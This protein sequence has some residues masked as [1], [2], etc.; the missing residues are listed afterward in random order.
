MRLSR[1]IFPIFV[2]V[3]FVPE[4]VV[5]QI[6]AEIGHSTQPATNDGYIYLIIDF[7]IPPYE[8]AWDS[9]NEGNPIDELS[10]GTYCVTV[11]DALCCTAT[12]CFIVDSC[13]EIIIT[14]TVIPA[15][16]PFATNG[17]VS[18]SATGGVAPYEFDWNI[19]FSGPDLSGLI[20][21][22]YCVLVKDANNCKNALCVDVG[23]KCEL[24]IDTLAPIC[25]YGSA[26]LEVSGGSGDYSYAWS[27][28][29]GTYSSEEAPV[30]L[31]SGFG[32]GPETH[33]VTVTDN[34]TGCQAKLV[35]KVE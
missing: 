11:S 35:V 27:Y 19:G 20:P 29:L 34:Q 12:N 24:T 4:S 25:S 3:F 1:I 22:R 8:F 10:P 17:N 5:A 33:T 31:H 32:N 2:S 28:W 14:K 30:I 6:T 13:P 7:G 26:E 18:V 23:Y 15:T 21:D 9:S 16:G